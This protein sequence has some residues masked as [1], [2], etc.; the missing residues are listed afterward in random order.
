MATGT[1]DT[2]VLGA[3]VASFSVDAITHAPSVT[4]DVIEKTGTWDNCLVVIE[5]SPDTGTTWINTNFSVRG[6]G[7]VTMPYCA[8]TDVR[9][10]VVAAEGSTSTVTI[11]L[12]AK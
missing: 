5:K 11:H 12:L 10:V 2:N 8:C 3:T 4:L 9:A 1:L 6:I 7:S